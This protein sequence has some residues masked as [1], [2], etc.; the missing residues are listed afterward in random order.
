VSDNLIV[1]FNKTTEMG[2]IAQ[3]AHKYD[4]PL[5]FTVEMKQLRRLAP[6]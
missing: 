5:G 6:P 1:I 2:R 4:L 3:L